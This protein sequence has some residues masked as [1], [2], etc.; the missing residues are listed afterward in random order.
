VEWQTVEY[1]ANRPDALPAYL[2]EGRAPYGYACAW[3]ALTSLSPPSSFE[4][5]SRSS[6][7]TGLASTNGSGRNDGKRGATIRL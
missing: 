3:A 5:S 1:P 6:T 7:S 4:S 2:I